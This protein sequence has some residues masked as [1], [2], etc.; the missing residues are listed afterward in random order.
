MHKAIDMLTVRPQHIIVDGNK[1]IDYQN[2]YLTAHDCFAPPGTPKHE[3]LIHPL[4]FAEQVMKRRRA[5]LT[6][7]WIAGVSD[8]P[9]IGELAHVAVYR[10]TPANRHDSIASRRPQAQRSQRTRDRRVK[11]I[12][13]TLRYQMGQ[14]RQ[15]LE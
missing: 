11:V 10:G 3:T 13:R 2:I 12:Y 7:Q 14:H 6:P 4:L 9:P 8:L 5:A 1:F 15:R